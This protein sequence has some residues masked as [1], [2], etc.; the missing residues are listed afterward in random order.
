L[1]HVRPDSACTMGSAIYIHDIT[2]HVYDLAGKPCGSRG[3][4]ALVSSQPRP[5]EFSSSSSFSPPLRC[6]LAK[7][8]A[9]LSLFLVFFLQGGVFVFRRIRL[10]GC[11]CLRGMRIRSEFRKIRD[12]ESLQSSVSILYSRHRAADS[13]SKSPRPNRLFRLGPHHVSQ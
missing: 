1:K 4:S 9:P 8:H 11:G 5:V 10:S 13:R 12:L 7:P 6:D 2:G 3:E